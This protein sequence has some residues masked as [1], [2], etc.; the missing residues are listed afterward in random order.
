MNNQPTANNPRTA[1]EQK[2]NSARTNL[3]IMLGLT[4][5]N[6]VLLFTKSD[7]MLLFSATI[8]YLATAFGIGI[9]ERGFSEIS[10]ALFGASGILII[11]YL[12]CWIFSKKHY[13]WMIVALALFVLDTATLILFYLY[14]GDFS[15]ILDLVIHIAVL[16]YLISGVVSGNKLK[17][18]HPEFFVPQYNVQTQSQASPGSF[19][20][21][22]TESD[23]V[24]YAN[25]PIIRHADLSVKYRILIEANYNGHQ[26][27]Y[28]RV[29]RVNELVIDGY[30]YDEV[31]MLVE[32]AHS[33]NARIDNQNYQVGFDGAAHSYFK[34][35]GVQ[36]AK[37]LRLW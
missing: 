20:S 27:C 8:P 18:L 12:L 1:L 36:V 28:R 5:I 10:V 19:V 23:N 9:A 2:Y 33:L 35:D 34:V 24:I 25:S 6:I 16:F 17:N 15:G 13:G 4:I 26:V 31:E 37:K 22:N 30:V 32:G 7:V 29:K 14:I 21:E 11:L 3:L